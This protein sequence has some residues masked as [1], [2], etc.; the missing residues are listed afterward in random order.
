MKL[1]KCSM[2]KDILP[3]DLKESG[4]CHSIVIYDRKIER[5]KGQLFCKK[6]AKIIHRIVLAHYSD[7]NMRYLNSIG[8]DIKIMQ[9]NIEK[10]KE[11]VRKL[12]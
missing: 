5:Y 12:R 3:V 8:H 4:K 7:W 10:Y 11:N 2:C 9:S 6:C 1:T